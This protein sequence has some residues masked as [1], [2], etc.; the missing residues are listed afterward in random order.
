LKRQEGI[1]EM[2]MPR[3]AAAYGPAETWDGAEVAVGLVDAFSEAIPMPERITMTA[4]GFNA[5]AARAPQAI[6]LAVPPTSR[7]R[8]DAEML[9]QIVA[10]TR[11]LA[12]ARTVRLEDIEPAELNQAQAPSMWLGADGPLRIRLRPYPLTGNF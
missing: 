6:L 2:R 1:T 4:F 3:F 10:E 12:H 11:A 9:R 7:H 5:P 8:L